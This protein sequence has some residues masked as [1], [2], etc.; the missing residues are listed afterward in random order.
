MD[1]FL[2]D[3][4]ARWHPVDISLFPLRCYVPPPASLHH[5]EITAQKARGLRLAF[6]QFLMNLPP[7]RNTRMATGMDFEIYGMITLVCDHVGASPVAIINCL[8]VPNA[9][10]YSISPPPPAQ[11][12]MKEVVTVVYAWPRLVGLSSDTFSLTPA[13]PR[14]RCSGRQS[15]PAPGPKKLSARPL[16]QTRARRTSAPLPPPP[17]P[18]PPPQ[19][20]GSPLSPPLVGSATARRLLAGSGGTR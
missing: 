19:R 1:P 9:A 8:R 3:R 15:Y 6:L 2:S 5:H 14:T 20:K 7:L 11:R 12:T 18:P 17:P 16:L 10:P 4:H 13:I